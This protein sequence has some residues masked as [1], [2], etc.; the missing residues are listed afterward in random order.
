MTPQRPYDFFVPPY[1]PIREYYTAADGQIQDWGHKLLEAQLFY[2]K[3]KG[4]G[5]L[6]LS[7]DT[8]GEFIHPDL[9]GNNIP[10]FNQVIVNEGN[11]TPA[12]NHGHGT[13]RA[14]IAGAI[15][16][17]I[18]VIGIAP[19][20]NNAGVKVL[21]DNGGGFSSDVAKG[22][23]Y[24]AN[25]KTDL[26]KVIGLSLGGMFPSPEIEQAVDYAIS[27]GCIV[28]AA[29]GNRGCSGDGETM[30]YPGA[31]PQV[32]AWAS[33]DEDESPSS[34]SSCGKEVDLRSPGARILS[35]YKNGG[36]A[37]FSG[38]SMATPQGDGMSALIA[39]AYPEVFKPYNPSNQALMQEF[40]RDHASGGFLKGYGYGIPKAKPYLDNKPGDPNPPNPEP[41]P[42]PPKKKTGP[43]W[44]LLGLAI[45][46]FLIAI[47]LYFL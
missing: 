33:I 9:I 47:L 13:H 5:V 4:E 24:G 34:F 2:F 7:C 29:A 21:Y 3:T 42:E 19:R 37:R 14:G 41:N 20:S 16:N 17:N 46:A 27:Q 11:Y 6:I 25:L 30:D 32:I 10:E 8:A 44:L 18:G 26:I 40:L 1:W 12:D 35:T 43:N 31:Y 45:L 22:I 36:Y 15:D 38:T 23:M 39:S 28:N